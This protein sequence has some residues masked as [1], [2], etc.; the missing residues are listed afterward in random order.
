MKNLLVTVAVVVAAL[1]FSN[2]A[3][4]REPAAKSVA[5]AVPASMSTTVFMRGL[6][7]LR[8]HMKHV[9]AKLTARLEKEARAVVSKPGNTWM[10]AH[11]LLGLAITESDLKWWLKRGYGTVADCGLTQINLTS[12]RMS[13]RKKWSLCRMLRGKRKAPGGKTPTTLSMEWTMKELNHIKGKYCTASWLARIKRWHRWSK[14]RGLTDRQH[15]FRCI[16]SVYNQGP[17]WLPHR[18]NTCTFK[19]RFIEDPPQSFL[20]KK[21]AKCRSRNL[22]WLR[23]WCFGEGVRLGKAPMVK[24]RGRLRRVSCRRVWSMAYVKRIYS[25]TKPPA[26]KLQASLTQPRRPASLHPSRLA[27]S[28]AW[29]S[30]PRPSTSTLASTRK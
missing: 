10:P 27:G 7:A 18:Y 5:T 30:R 14:W 17:R 8:G 12:L 1:L 6:G 13:Y 9:D 26:P 3:A 20:D 2:R 29:R 19:H 21:A 22:Y 16:L 25:Y 24:R 11:L 28:K 15:F 4:A 23:A